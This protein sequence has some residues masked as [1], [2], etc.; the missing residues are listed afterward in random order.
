MKLNLN[1]V[2]VLYALSR[3]KNDRN[4]GGSGTLAVTMCRN[5]E[6]IWSCWFAREGGLAKL[7]E[8]QNVRKHEPSSWNW[9]GGE[10][11]GG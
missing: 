1:T 4:P 5:P 6:W 8:I 11:G 3:N 2:P 9:R 7:I 10:R